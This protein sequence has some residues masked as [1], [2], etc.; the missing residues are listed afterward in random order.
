M[1]LLAPDVPAVLM[2]MGFMTN[3]DDEHALA[4]TEHRERVM[5]AVGDAIDAYFAEEARY[6]M[7]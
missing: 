3:L 5:N 6:A 7:R 4:D 2:E 1:V